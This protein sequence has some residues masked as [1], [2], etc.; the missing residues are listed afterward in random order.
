LE[1]VEKYWELMGKS[2]DMLGLDPY[3][4]YVRGS[5]VVVKEIVK[6]GIGPL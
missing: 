2:W 5:A 1:N 3:W 4:E 6:L